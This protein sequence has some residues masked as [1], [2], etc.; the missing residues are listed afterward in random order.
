[1]PVATERQMVYKYGMNAEKNN[2]LAVH[3][4]E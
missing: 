4:G 1:M 2:F 3:L